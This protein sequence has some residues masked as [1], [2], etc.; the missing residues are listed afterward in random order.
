MSCDEKGERVV[1]AA[2]IDSIRG[3]SAQAVR[4]R[5]LLSPCHDDYNV[6]VCFYTCLVS[7]ETWGPRGPPDHIHLS[8]PWSRIDKL[9]GAM[10]A[11]KPNF[12][13]FS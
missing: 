5:Q 9:P 7:L 3:A 13:F 1:S 6:S 10:T 8:V 11:P 4:H 12:I 2:K